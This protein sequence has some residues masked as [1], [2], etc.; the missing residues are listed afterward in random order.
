MK[1]PESLKNVLSE[2]DLADIKKNLTSR[3]KFK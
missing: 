1:I 3:F 2:A